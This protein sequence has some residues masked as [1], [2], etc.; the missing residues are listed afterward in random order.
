MLH[1]SVKGRL[2]VA[3]LDEMIKGVLTAVHDKVRD[4]AIADRRHGP[5]FVG[6][7]QGKKR[8]SG[9]K[10]KKKGKKEKR[11]KKKKKGERKIFKL[12]KHEKNVSGTGIKPSIRTSN[13]MSRAT[14]AGRPYFLL[15][16][17]KGLDKMIILD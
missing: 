3:H 11:K 14:T 17:N 6:T 2:I 5:N 8:E 12:N 16:V 10:W 13:F 4:L 9:R 15:K 7:D 1:D